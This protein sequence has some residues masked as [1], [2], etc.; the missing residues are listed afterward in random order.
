MFMEEEL[1]EHP[2]LREVSKDA[3]M[4]KEVISR[5][6]LSIRRGDVVVIL[7]LDGFF[8]FYVICR[9]IVDVENACRSFVLQVPEL[10]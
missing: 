10:C 4:H 8:R 6:L 7:F 5:V 2:F 9:K 3:T 1:C